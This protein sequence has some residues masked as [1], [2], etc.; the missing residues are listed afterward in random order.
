MDLK[1]NKYYDDILNERKKYN[2]LVPH[3]L[4]NRRETE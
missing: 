2:Q 3:A 4:K 1:R